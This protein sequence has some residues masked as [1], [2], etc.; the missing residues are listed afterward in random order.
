MKKIGSYEAKPRFSQILGAVG[1][2][3]E[4]LITNH[5]KAIAKLVPVRERKDRNV[6]EVVADLL[7]FQTRTDCSNVS[8]ED[9]QAA[10]QAGRP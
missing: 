10:R 1:D 4:F 6:S 5:G 2:G 9:V 3:E 7:A 8:L